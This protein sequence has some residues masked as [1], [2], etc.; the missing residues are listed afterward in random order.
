MRL[1]PALAT[2]IGGTQAGPAAGCR[3]AASP[4]LPTS[5]SASIR[6]LRYSTVTVCSGLPLSLRHRQ[7]ERRKQ[8][9]VHTS[10]SLHGA[11]CRSTGCH[12]LPRLPTPTA[13]RTAAARP[14]GARM[15]PRHAPSAARDPQ[16][17]PCLPCSIGVHVKGRHF[18]GVGAGRLPG[19]GPQSPA[20]SAQRGPRPHPSTCTC[21]PLRTWTASVW[22]ACAAA[23]ASLPA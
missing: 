10:L 19:S 5:A 17:C 22:P 15:R 13:Q 4:A 18:A 6:R 12:I 16:S 9:Y 23:A 11:A 8:L 21:P 2:K 20:T 3:A 7:T 14:G 1:A